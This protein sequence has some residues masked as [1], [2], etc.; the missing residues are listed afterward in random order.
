MCSVK[1][2]GGNLIILF[3]VRNPHKKGR[4]IRK[5]YNVCSPEVSSQS[6]QPILSNST[7]ESS[8][9]HLA[10]CSNILLRLRSVIQLLLFQTFERFV[11]GMKSIMTNGRERRLLASSDQ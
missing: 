3:L 6:R 7:V 8:T 10:I 9:I 2:T 5:W 1:G 11:P 4:R